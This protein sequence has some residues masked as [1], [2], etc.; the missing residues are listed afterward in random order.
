[1]Y[2]VTSS[3]TR[4]LLYLWTVCITLMS[5]LSSWTVC[6]VAQGT[7]VWKA[8]PVKSIPSALAQ[9]DQPL[10]SAIYCSVSSTHCST[11][12]HTVYL[13][14]GGCLALT[15]YKGLLGHGGDGEDPLLPSPSICRNYI[16]FLKH[17]YTTTSPVPSWNG[18]TYY[19]K[20]T[21][22]T[23]YCFVN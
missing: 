16:L 20:I 9:V 12:W 10:E 18:Y 13:E 23:I 2:F 11:L 6:Y 3:R 1:M 19:I 22:L 5:F 17:F 7:M 14:A 4:M 21:I 15:R 8:N